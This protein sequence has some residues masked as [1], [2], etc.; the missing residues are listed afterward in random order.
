MGN[1]AIFLSQLGEGERY[2]KISDS[3]FS[4]AEPWMGWMGGAISAC[5]KR[6]SNEMGLSVTDGKT[7]DVASKNVVAQESDGQGW[8]SFFRGFRYDSDNK[9]KTEIRNRGPGTK[10]PGGRLAATAY[11][12]VGRPFF[13]NI[14]YAIWLIL[15]SR[16]ALRWSVGRPKKNS[17]R[18]INVGCCKIRSDESS[19]PGRTNCRLGS[20]GSLGW[21]AVGFVI[22]HV[23]CRLTCCT[24]RKPGLFCGLWRKPATFYS[25]NRRLMHRIRLGI[26]VCVSKWMASGVR[27]G[28]SSCYGAGNRRNCRKVRLVQARCRTGRG[29]NLTR[30]FKYLVVGLV[31]VSGICWTKQSMNCSAAHRKSDVATV[32]VDS[33]GNGGRSRSVWLDHGRE[34][35]PEADWLHASVVAPTVFVTPPT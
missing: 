34:V 25:M 17:K 9:K 22:A 28:S 29:H 12:P 3:T 30:I 14:I 24:W 31:G 35:V 5:G 6:A 32:V 4:I 2:R 19:S 23:V 20:R 18:R 16:L 15:F 21:T 13:D 7:N 10:F 8:L 27:L 33:L 26:A 11:V 1:W